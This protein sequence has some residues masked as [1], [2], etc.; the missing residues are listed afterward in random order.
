MDPHSGLGPRAQM[1]LER[2]GL[3]GATNSL[4]L[5]EIVALQRDYSSDDAASTVSIDQDD[6]SVPEWTPATAIAT[7]PIFGFAELIIV[8]EAIPKPN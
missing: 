3:S 6:S 8:L 5:E 2:A 1:A 4:T 7:D